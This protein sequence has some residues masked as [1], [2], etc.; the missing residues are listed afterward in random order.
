M[1]STG[2]NQPKDP[3]SGPWAGTDD[4][5]RAPSDPHAPTVSEA[6][7]PRFA[8]TYAGKLDSKGRVII[9][10]VFRQALGGTLYAFPSLTENVVQLGDGSLPEMILAA[11]Q[12][13][14]AVDPWSERLTRLQNYIFQQAQP[15]SMDD[16]GRVTVPDRHKG[17]ANLEGPLT[18][19]GRG[20]H[21]ILAPTAFFNTFDAD[22][23]AMAAE[24][25]EILGAKMRPKAGGGLSS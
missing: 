24:F 20:G 11:A 23:E 17:H 13:L 14:D 5:P 10:P 7:G 3:G 15:V 12:D 19:A 9:P 1:A 4:Q 2:E 21:F 6:R 25:A 16:A 22:A 18:F 8:G